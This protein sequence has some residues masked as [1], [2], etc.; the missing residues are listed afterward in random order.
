MY[1]GRWCPKGLIE[2]HSSQST[3]LPADAPPEVAEALTDLLVA[4]EVCRPVGTDGKHDA[5]HTPWCGCVD[6]VGVED[7]WTLLGGGDE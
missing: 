2:H 1:P 5:R 4:L 6:K 7:D 3:Y